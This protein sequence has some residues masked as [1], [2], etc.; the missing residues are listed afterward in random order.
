MR[1]VV[2]YYSYSGNTRKVTEALA[3]HLRQKGEAQVMELIALDE[4]KNFFGQCRRAF[5]HQ[6]AKLAPVNFD[7]SGFDLVC[8][9]T[10]V[11]AFGSTPAMNAYL[12]K[13]SGVEGKEIILFVTCGS[14]TGVGRC[15][16]YMQGAL[17][18]KGAGLA[19]RMII[20]QA[21]IKDRAFILSQV[22]EIMRLSFD[23][24]LG[25]GGAY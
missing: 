22:Q 2:I 16:E 11:W 12:D 4:S 8:F 9:G 18:K 20:P 1:S 14:G 10:P 3:E 6:Q 13:C 7:L 5:R 17:A 25:H 19:K 21:K 24:T 23:Y 15:L